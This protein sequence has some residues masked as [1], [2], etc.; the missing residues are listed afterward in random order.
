MKIKSTCLLVVIFCFAM[1][2]F[3]PLYAQPLAGTDGLGR[4]LALHKEVG[5]LKLDRKVVLF[6]FLWQGDKSS[7]TSEKVWDLAK[8]SVSH[9][10]VFEDFDHPGWGG[11][12]GKAGKYYFWGEPLYG[13]YEGHDYWVHLKNI[14]LLTDAGVDVLAIDATN[15]LTYGTQA[16]VLMRAM[17]TVRLQGKNPPKIVFY[18]HTASGEGMQEIY[19]NCYREGAPYRY[20]DSWFYLDEK[21]LIIGLSDQAK[22]KDYESFFT[23]RESQW[24]NEPQKVNGWPWIEFTRPQQVYNNAR[25]QKEIVNVSTAQHPNLEASMGGSAFYGAI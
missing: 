11:G 23:I 9:P 17:E 1:L 22:G 21:P 15:R 16:D 20:P 13:Y 18:T 7:P 12:A 4:T 14:Q 8:L 10:E 2:F 24:P 3:N 6:Y 5:D 19:D 25:G